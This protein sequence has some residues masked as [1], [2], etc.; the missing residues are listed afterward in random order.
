[1]RLASVSTA[2]N[3]SPLAFQKIH[4]ATAGGPQ[5]G[6]GEM[7]ALVDSLLKKWPFLVSIR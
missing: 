3:D 5:N 4:P 7:V 1:M 6:A 2:L